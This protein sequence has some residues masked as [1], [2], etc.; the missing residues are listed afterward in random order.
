MIDVDLNQMEPRDLMLNNP[1]SSLLS[2]KNRIFCST[3]GIPRIMNDMAVFYQF[4]FLKPDEYWSIM[5]GEHEYVVIAEFGLATYFAV[6]KYEDM[7][8]IFKSND[9]PGWISKVNTS[10][11]K[12]MLSMIMRDRVITMDDDYSIEN[13]KIDFAYL[14][15]DLQN[16]LLLTY[17]GGF[18][19]IEDDSYY[20]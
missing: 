12:L 3:I 7:V 6:R 19:A 10:I 18:I 9:N 13:F 4:K 11:E 15:P 2:E 16:D 17:W 8:Y 20:G 5:H 14:E 1:L